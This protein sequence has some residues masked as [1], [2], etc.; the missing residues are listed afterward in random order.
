MNKCHPHLAEGDG[1]GNG[2]VNKSAWIL[3]LN[4]N[5]GK[6]LLIN[7]SK[8]S[9][10]SANKPNGTRLYILHMGSDIQDER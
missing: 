7:L 2:G 5:L 3:A 10:C 8:T 1:K 4:S 9:S 6:K